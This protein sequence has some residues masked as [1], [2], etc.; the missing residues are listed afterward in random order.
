MKLI[1]IGLVFM[2][3]FPA[4]LSATETYPAFSRDYWQEQHSLATG[5]MRRGAGLAALGLISIW[6]TSLMISKAV[7]NPQKY[8][9]LSAVFA[10]ATLGASLH[11]FGSVGFGK[12]ERDA[13]TSFMDA[14]DANPANVD[15]DA[16]KSEFVRDKQKSTRKILIFGSYLATLSTV[17][18]SN[19][20]YQTVRK[21]RDADM[22]GIRIWPYYLA[23]GLLLAAGGGIIIRSKMKLDDLALLKA[24]DSE[25]SAPAGLS[26]QFWMDDNG[27]P[28]VAISFGSR[29]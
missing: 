14:Y 29:F 3:L 27:N 2:L 6:P 25:N 5:K 26:P 15:L 28:S 4:T 21:Q 20:I 7:D 23:G 13:A 24:S 8:T 19:A 12:K 22:A 18:L 10:M 1:V 11:G 9:A 16:Q 17:L